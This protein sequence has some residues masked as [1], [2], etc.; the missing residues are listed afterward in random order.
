MLLCSVEQYKERPKL[1]TDK[2]DL[3]NG[4]HSGTMRHQ[5]AP[6]FL[7]YKSLGAGDFHT[8]AIMETKAFIFML[9]NLT[10]MVMKTISVTYRSLFD[11]QCNVNA[12]QCLV[13][14]VSFSTL[15]LQSQC[16]V[17]ARHHLLLVFV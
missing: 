16:K 11:C 4:V 2:S 14:F 8:V 1:V 9:I 10:P 7:L 6:S 3:G 13:F 17:R 15:N 12:M 5:E